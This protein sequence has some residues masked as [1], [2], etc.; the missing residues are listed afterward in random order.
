ML[1]LGT[2]SKGLRL[3]RRR[4]CRLADKSVRRTTPS[5]TTGRRTLTSTRTTANL[6][7][8]GTSIAKTTSS[9]GRC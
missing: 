5:S 3:A 1:M 7:A 8:A 6:S 4:D 9:N 2:N